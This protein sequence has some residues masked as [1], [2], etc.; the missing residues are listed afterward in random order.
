MQLCLQMGP[1]G[2]NLSGLYIVS[3]AQNHPSGLVI[4]T[5]QGS[6][7]TIA[8]HGIDSTSSS[9]STTSPVSPSLVLPVSPSVSQNTVCVENQKMVGLKPDGKHNLLSPLV[10]G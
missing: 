5:P 10:K 4:S 1:R 6:T 2:A 8:I 3:E 7:L 9:A